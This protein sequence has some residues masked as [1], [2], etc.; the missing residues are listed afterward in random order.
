MSPV[1]IAFLCLY[2]SIIFVVSVY[3]GHRYVM[4]FLYYK[5]K[6]NDHEVQPFDGPLPR[7]TVQL[8][9]YN[10]MYVCERLIES[11]CAI[12]YPRGLLEI[13]VLD[14]STD[15]TQAIAAAAVERFRQRGV[16]IRYLH[17]ADRRGYKAGALE[18]GLK[19]AKG[20]L[21]A[22]FDAD[23]V[24]DPDFLR[25]TVPHFSDAGVGMVQVRWGHL[26]R[27][28]S[29]LTQAQSIMLDGH[30]MIE[31]TARNRS[32]RF[33]NFNGTAGIWRREA[34]L[35]AGGWAHDTLTEDLDLSY[36]AQLRGWK[37][38]FLPHVVSPAEVPVEM[39]A[40]KSQQHRWAKGSI[41]TA[42]KLLPAIFRAKLPLS[43][44]V[45]A[46]FHLTNNL[47]YL[48]MVLISLLMPIAVAV[49]YSH[50]WYG[51][52][53]LDF[54]FFIAAT[55]SV[56]GFYIAS[57]REVGMGWGQ[58]L[59][60]LPFLMS[61]GIGLSIN[62]ARAVIEALFNHQSEFKRTPKHGVVNSAQAWQQLR[63]RGSWVSVQPFLELALGL[64][65]SAA[66]WYVVDLGLWA[67]LP[68]LVLSQVGFL[69][70]GLMSLFQG[71]FHRRPLVVRAQ[72]AETGGAAEAA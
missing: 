49:R 38:I 31:H 25:R 36:R 6:Y 33:F 59:R 46:F 40:F 44:K 39:N 12:Q 23:F 67:S 55:L 17:R 64:Y 29:A 20:E 65:L 9:I 53:L 57:Q 28:F 16:D 22:V 10:E 45:E 14:D 69:Y 71:R 56:S 2:F 37:F 27:A 18:A 47:A 35:D 66:V 48:L 4:A 54:P 63:Y 50:G 34:I 68:F 43:V 58:R 61:L 5:H 26:N 41:Q 60:Y 51:V 62:N 42:K 1:E 30:F 15:E 32:G 24:P 52:L 70:V 72:E 13:Q 7:V 19:V 8:P 3:G 21:V 11:V